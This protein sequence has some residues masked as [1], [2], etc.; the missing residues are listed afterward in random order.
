MGLAGRLRR[1]SNFRPLQDFA[2]TVDM[3][4]KE[5]G[6]DFFFSRSPADSVIETWRLQSESLRFFP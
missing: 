5:T 6:L 2:V 3:V 4:E 1:V